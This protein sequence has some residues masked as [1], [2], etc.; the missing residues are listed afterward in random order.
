MKKH[1]DFQDARRGAVIPGTDKTSITLM[2]YTAILDAARKQADEA[3]VG[4]QTIINDLLGEALGVTPTANTSR[5][6]K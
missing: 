1:Y 6:R 5:T 3:G 4:F 2:I